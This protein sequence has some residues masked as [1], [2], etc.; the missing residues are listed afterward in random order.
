[1][2]LPVRRLLD[3]K[4]FVYLWACGTPL[5]DSGSQENQLN[6]SRLQRETLN[7]H[8]LFCV[9]KLGGFTHATDLCQANRAPLKGT[10]M[11]TSTKIMDITQIYVVHY[12]A[13]GRL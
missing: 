5:V 6:S 1:M 8:Y 12:L 13:L 2:L 9:E 10:Y 4:Q 7:K 11:R 3:L